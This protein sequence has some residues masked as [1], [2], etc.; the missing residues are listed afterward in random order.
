MKTKYH[1][2][3]LSS[4]SSATLAHL[5]S[6]PVMLLCRVKLG[7]IIRDTRKRLLGTLK[8]KTIKGLGTHN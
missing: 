2:T 7:N 5:K 3:F 6:K 1:C 8:E 4:F